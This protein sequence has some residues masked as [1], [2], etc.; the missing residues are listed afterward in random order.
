MRRMQIA[1]L[2]LLL[3]LA[4]VGAAQHASY[5][6]TQQAFR[7]QLLAGIATKCGTAMTVNPGQRME[8]SVSG[9]LGTTT[10][11]RAV[12][13]R[14]GAVVGG[15]VGIATGQRKIVYSNA[16]SGVMSIH[17]T[18]QPSSGSYTVSG[19]IYVSD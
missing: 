14:T 18:A 13:S 3:A 16:G 1:V 19:T 7:C 10:Y 11:F 5:A 12:N 8:V 6:A 17:L 4:A 9:P 15:P 2:A